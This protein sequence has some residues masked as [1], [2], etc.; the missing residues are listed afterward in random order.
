MEHD[1]EGECARIVEER[2]KAKKRSISDDC[3]DYS[4]QVKQ[5]ILLIT[6]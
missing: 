4:E 2:E 1:K 6:N 3:E 5:S